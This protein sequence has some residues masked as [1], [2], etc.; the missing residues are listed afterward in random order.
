VLAAWVLEMVRRSVRAIVALLL[1][2]H[3][4]VPR[5]F[6]RPGLLVPSPRSWAFLPAR[7]RAP[8]LNGCT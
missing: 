2:P 8:P 6:P 1:T 7:L 3:P 4:A 5:T